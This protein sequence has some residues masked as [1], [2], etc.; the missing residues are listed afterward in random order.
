MSGRTL[1][2]AILVGFLGLANG[3]V[4]A[5]GT[6]AGLGLEEETRGR[7][8]AVLRGGLGSKEFW[9]GMHA[10]EALSLSGHGEEVRAAVTP[11]LPT[12]SDEQR[13]CG[14]ARELVRAG[15]LASTRILLNALEK[16]DPYGHVHA[17]ESLFKVRQIGDGA[18]LRGALARAE[19]PSLKIMAA[20]ALARWGSPEALAVLREKA[21]A[22]DGD[23]A[24][25]AAWVLAR[26]GDRSDLALLRAGARRFDDPLTRAYFEHALAALGDAEG[27]AKLIRN[28]E[29]ADP[30]V[31][32]YA[33]EFAP[34]ARAVEAK[35]ALVRIL[36]DPVLD[37]R[38]RAAEALLLLAGPDDSRSG[39]MFAREI[40]P[41]SERN[42]RY[43]EG[44][45]LVLRDGR[46]LYAV[47][48]FEGNGSDFAKARIVAVESADEG[49]TW[50]AS[51]VVQE[52]VGKNNVMSVTLRRLSPTSVF[53]GPIGLFYLVKNSTTDLHVFLRVSEDEGSTFGPPIRVTAEPGYHV[54][55]NDRVTVLSSGRLVVPVASTRDVAGG[56]EFASACY[57]SDDQGKTW[58]RGKGSAKFPER[59]AMEP[60]VLELEGGRL[61]MHFRTQFGY[62]ALSESNDRGETWSE[63]RSWGVRAPEAP[64]TLRRIP[65]TGDLLLIWNDTFR[66]G[67]GHGGKRTPLTAAV[68][69][70]EGKTWAH[71]RDL[72]SSDKQTYAYA[73]VVFNRGRALLTYYVC[74]EASG[75]ISSRFRSTPIAWFYERPASPATESEK[76]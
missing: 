2:T 59:G 60:E 31:R 53:D 57:L 9:P 25:I 45:V 24:R 69:T 38:I 6:A 76:P 47:T 33:A 37:V 70:D 13:R 26:T 19:K 22:E 20:A 49:R 39:E 58:R 67:D 63:P 1:R 10:A 14:L 15:D 36:D 56:G 40:F 73:S 11:R 12:E 43:S 50:G 61:L 30:M 16:A 18:S 8:L 3:P 46:L 27:R 5:D 44:S 74:D 34:E 75:R 64:S 28:L 29:H 41:A 48:E 54:L 66:Q 71:R 7:C 51:R 68:S 72:E 4:R 21:T 62:I 32:V 23:T 52:N 35:E 17:C 42:P 65:S 55:N